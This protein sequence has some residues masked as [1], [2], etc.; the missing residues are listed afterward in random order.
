MSAEKLL[1]E[2]LRPNQ[3]NKSCHRET[4]YVVIASVHFFHKAGGFILDTVGAGLV[5]RGSRWL[6]NC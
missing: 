2:L 4:D 6:H 1:F 3:L 5:Q